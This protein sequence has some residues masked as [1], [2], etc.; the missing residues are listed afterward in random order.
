MFRNFKFSESTY[1]F[2]VELY[3]LMTNL[4]LFTTLSIF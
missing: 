2:Y 1:M 3:Y 4:S